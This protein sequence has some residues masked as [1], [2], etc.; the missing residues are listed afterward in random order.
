MGVHRM[1][2]QSKNQLGVQLVSRTSIE[3]LLRAEERGIALEA[4]IVLG[5][6]PCI[7]IASMAWVPFGE[8]KLALAGSLLGKPVK[9]VKGETVDLEFPADAMIVL[10]GKFIPS[11]RREEGPFGESTG[12]YITTSSPVVEIHLAYHQLEPVYPVFQPWTYED[13]TIFSFAWGGEIIAQ[14]KKIFPP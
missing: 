4:A 8:N 5:V 12:Y 6:H 3:Y 10:E 1:Q 11:L 9:V 2:V 13:D 7:L 14:L